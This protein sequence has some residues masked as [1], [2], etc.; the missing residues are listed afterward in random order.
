MLMLRCN[1]ALY[2]ECGGGGTSRLLFALALAF[3][4]C[5]LSTAPLLPFLDATEE[6]L[7]FR[8]AEEEAAESSSQLLWDE[9]LESGLRSVRGG[10]RSNRSS[11]EA[12]KEVEED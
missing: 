2:L 8:K 7:L 4:V 9:S 12:E 1:E 6:E 5:A 11:H 10:G 3:A